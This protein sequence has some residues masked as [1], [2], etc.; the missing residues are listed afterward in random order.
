VPPC[1]RSFCSSFSHIIYHLR[2]F[3]ASYVHIACLP[4]MLFFEEL[5]KKHSPS[6]Q[7]NICKEFII[8]SLLTLNLQSLIKLAFLC[9][10]VL[11]HRNELLLLRITAPLVSPPVNSYIY[12]CYKLMLGEKYLILGLYSRIR[13][14]GGFLVKGFARRNE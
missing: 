4:S 14:W 12:L 7:P 11:C 9:V 5:K 1:I 6:L 2:Q 10:H 3:Y 13:V 8:N